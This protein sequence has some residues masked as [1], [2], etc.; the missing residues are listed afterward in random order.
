VPGEV[1]A[2]AAELK[3]LDPDFRLLCVSPAAEQGGG[4][5]AVID[6]SGSVFRGYTAGEGTFYLARPD[7]HI[8]ARW[9]N[10]VPSEVT[11]VLQSILRGE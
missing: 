11:A 3:A 1:S 7:R 5:N 8:A 2:L 9:H 6:A 4:D 10:V